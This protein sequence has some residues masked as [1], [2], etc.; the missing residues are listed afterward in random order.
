MYRVIIAG[1]GTGAMTLCG[2]LIRSGKV[3]PSEIAVIDPSPLHYYQPGFTI[4]A[5][6]L[7]GNSEKIKSHMDY[8]ARDTRSLF[9]PDINFIP[10]SV[11]GFSPS[12]N[13]ISIGNEEISYDH[14]VVAL[15]LSLDYDKVPGLYEALEDENSPVGTIYQFKYCLKTNRLI[16]S[17][18]GGQAIFSQPNQPFKC[19]GAPQ[20][21][22][23]LSNSSW[24]NSGIRAKTDI[25][26][27]I[28][29]PAMF[30]VPIYAK[31]LEK[32]AKGKGCNLHFQ[33]LLTKVDHK[34]NEAIFKKGDEEITVK[35]DFLHTA[36]PQSPP[37]VLHGSPISNEAGYVDVNP[38][39]LRHNKYDNIWAIGDCASCPTSKTAAAAIAEAPVLV[40][41]ICKVLDK[42]QPNAKYEGYTSCPIF[43][44]NNKLMLCEFKYQGEL[45]ET[46]GG[47]TT[48]S[49]YAYYLVKDILPKVYFSLL[50][51]G[52]W[53]GRNSFFKPKYN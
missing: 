41:N 25:Q 39:T 53:Y 40:N 47:Q 27:Y 5:G 13:K 14:L 38:N 33:H 9:H 7:R 34:K 23:Y 26:F 20:K 28:P 51:K 35:Y 15:G 43:L 8:I 18:K 52:L 30:S 24:T 2:Q 31:E 29:T 48:P 4:L 50:P 16:Q 42:A 21:I 22:M 11:T 10:K 45:D 44:G 1:A 49:T 37:K 46:F 19:A 6:G 3:K 12:S 32:I 36:P 17:F